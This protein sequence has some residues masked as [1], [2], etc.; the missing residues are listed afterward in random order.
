MTF[1]GRQIVGDL[2]HN[3]I[4]LSVDGRKVSF[5]YYENFD[6]DPHPSLRFGMRVYLPKAT[7]QMRDFSSSLNPPILHR[8]DQLVSKSYPYYFQFRELT[9]AEEQA[10]LLSRNDIGFRR[11]WDEL[12]ESQ[13]LQ[14]EGHTLREATGI[15]EDGADTTTI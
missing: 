10:G 12:L 13:K 9:T 4:K 15:K 14:I 1:A 6:D 7:Y 11:Q 8:K 3:V 5:L 2:G